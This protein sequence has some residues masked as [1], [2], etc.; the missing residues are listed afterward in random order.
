MSPFRIPFF[1]KHPYEVQLKQDALA[2]GVPKGERIMASGMGP[3][4][5]QPP[6]VIATDRALYFSGADA[7]ASADA[8]PV[9]LAW[10][11]ITRAGWEEPWLTIDTVHGEK[12]TLHLDPAGELPPVVRDRVTASVLI[13][14][15]VPLDI[16]GSV[17]CVG[18]REPGSD[19]VMW[20][21]EFDPDTD[22]QSTEIR[23]S[24]DR[25]LGELR[26]TLG[27]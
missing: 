10:T 23:A 18:R 1:T 6:V 5:Y 24:A 26:A 17:V 22:V 16:G 7:D 20:L 2:L 14:E 4:K 3:A 8:K 21:V 15:R 12:I 25:A 9:R 19:R 27:V 13:R 11:E